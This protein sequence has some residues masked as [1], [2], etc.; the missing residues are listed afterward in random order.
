M[1]PELHK[2]FR[3]TGAFCLRHCFKGWE[4][5][6][7]YLI[8]FPH[9][10]MASVSTFIHWN[11]KKYCIIYFQNISCSIVLEEISCIISVGFFIPDFLMT[12]YTDHVCFTWKDFTISWF[13]THHFTKHS[14]DFYLSQHKCQC[15]MF[16]LLKWAVAVEETQKQ[17][18]TIITSAQMT[19]YSMV[20][21]TTLLTHSFLLCWSG[22]T[23]NLALAK[24]SH[25]LVKKK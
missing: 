15:Y 19:W 20:P 8:V 24:S 25:F 12:L 11:L 16:I 21:T 2:R 3:L 13:F 22:L 14:I 18:G 7:Q 9:M 6:S 1:F 4:V 10:W 17:R 23:G 5:S